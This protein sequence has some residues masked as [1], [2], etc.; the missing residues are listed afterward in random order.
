MSSVF[1]AALATAAAGVIFGDSSARR[2]PCEQPTAPPCERRAARGT[3]GRPTR[4]SR[5]LSHTGTAVIDS[6]G[7][8]VKVPG[9]PSSRE[10]RRGAWRSMG[11]DPRPLLSLHQL[12]E[13]H[14]VGSRRPL[15]RDL[16]AVV[17]VEN[18]RVETRRSSSGPVPHS[19]PA[20]R[21]RRPRCRPSRG[22]PGGG[23]S[24]FLSCCRRRRPGESCSSR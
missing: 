9:V 15:R 1:F 13:V 19:S 20:G 5:T 23:W 7:T 11:V 14:R 2:C 3:H 10:L 18:G 12:P 8:S 16:G 17:A 24:C 21:C 6:T 4:T 22:D